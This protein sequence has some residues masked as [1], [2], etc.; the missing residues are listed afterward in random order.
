MQPGVPVLGALGL[1]AQLD[2]DREQLLLRAVVEIPRDPAPLVP[3]R[4]RDEIAA[5]RVLEFLCGRDRG[6]LQWLRSAVAGV[7]VHVFFYSISSLRIWP[8]PAD[9]PHHRPKLLSTEN[10]SSLTSAASP[11]EGRI[12][13]SG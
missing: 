8:D 7:S 12:T 6:G 5:R 10:V 2:R 3:A 4:P 11:T 9:V 1:E 13:F